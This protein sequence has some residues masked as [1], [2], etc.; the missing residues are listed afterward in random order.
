MFIVVI[1]LQIVLKYFLVAKKKKQADQKIKLY[2]QLF[3]II[4]R[5]SENQFI[6]SLEPNHRNVTPSP[7]RKSDAQKIG[8]LPLKIN[9]SEMKFFVITTFF[10]DISWRIKL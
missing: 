9:H 8:E 1:P 6:K 10:V 7:F 2:S 3:Q 4:I 5:Y